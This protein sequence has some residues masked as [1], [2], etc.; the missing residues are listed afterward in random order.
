MAQFELWGFPAYSHTSISPALLASTNTA[1]S[2]FSTVASP[3]E[4][5]HLL[6]LI[7]TQT[8]PCKDQSPFMTVSTVTPFECTITFPATSVTRNSHTGLTPFFNSATHLSFSSKCPGPGLCLFT[9]F[10]LPAERSDQV[11]LLESDR[12]EPCILNYYIS[13]LPAS[14]PLSLRPAAMPNRLQ[15]WLSVLISPPLLHFSCSFY[16]KTPLSHS[17]SLLNA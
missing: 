11:T 9:F 17:R 2:W 13:P 15:Y 16:L 3:W 7:L 10:M 6:L 14:P 5:H 1:P 4:L 8:T 12:T